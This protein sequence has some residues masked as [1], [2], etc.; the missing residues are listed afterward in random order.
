[1][2]RKVLLTGIIIAASS[3]AALAATPYVGGSL[4]VVDLGIYNSGKVQA[5]A[6]G[7]LFGGYGST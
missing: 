2:F 3:T 5:G 4:G 6:I 1:M 7:K